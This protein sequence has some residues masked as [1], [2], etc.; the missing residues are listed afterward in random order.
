MSDTR[1]IL[2]IEDNLEV[3]ENLEEI[4]TLS[5]YDISVAEN[6]LAGVQK[7]LDIHPDLILCDVMMPE[8]DGY[9][10]LNIL[11]K[12]RQ[13]ASTP[14]I[15]ITA[16][17]EKEDIRRG[18]N[19]GA[20]DYITKPFYK[21][22]LLMVIE[23]RLKKAAL[24]QQNTKSFPTQLTDAKRGLKTLLATIKEEGK[25]QI[26]NKRAYIV[27][28]GDHAREVF[29]VESGHVHLSRPHEYGKEYIF[30]E[31]GPGD[32]FGY[33]SLFEQQPFHYKAQVAQEECICYQ[34]P[35]KR[36][37][38]LINTDQNVAA[39]VL[40][41]MAGILLGQHEKLTN[42]AYDSVRRRTALVLS[43]LFEKHGEATITIQREDLAQMVGTA[44]ESVIRALSDFKQ[45]GLI[46]V[47]G[48]KISVEKQKELRNLMV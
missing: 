26:Y 41:L 33:A 7:A 13:T 24:V 3:R 4:L 42:Q 37:F 30:A 19:L 9:G 16:K 14:F 17:T 11:S 35:A 34:L 46:S 45:A 32:L 40:N 28:D 21:D 10:V 12:N 18:M 47:K 36:F 1:K 25:K 38:N 22:E 2:I 31:L 20:D 8:L 39:A 48:S 27:R 15:F 5:G 43:D 23:A 29:L 6:G 44:K